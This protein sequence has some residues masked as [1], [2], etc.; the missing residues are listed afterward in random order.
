VND[1]RRPKGW[2]ETVTLAGATEPVLVTLEERP[3]HRVPL[4]QVDP[5]EPT[6]SRVP[7]FDGDELVVMHA[8]SHVGL[9]TTSEPGDMTRFVIS[10]RAA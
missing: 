9:H 5:R 2:L 1:E 6:P 4:R 3:G 7:L 8:I 10:M